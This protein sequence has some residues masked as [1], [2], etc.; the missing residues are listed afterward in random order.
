MDYSQYP[1]SRKEAQQTKAKYYF[2]GIPCKHGHI[3]LRKTKGSCVECNKR[4]WQNPTQKRI[5]YV[6]AYNKSE[7]GKAM[8]RRYY[9]ANKE[10]VIARAQSRPDEDKRRYKAKHK[11]NNPEYYC[12]LAGLRHRRSKNARPKWLTATQKMEIRLK[13]RLAVALTKATG[14]KYVVDHIVPLQGKTV[15]GLHVSWNLQVITQA[16]NCRKSNKL[17]D[18]LL[19]T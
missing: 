1:T 7:V 17:L 12:E 6:K 3:A 9:E 18:N 2:T 4:D 16:E 13:Y 11:K 8:K 14:I 15:C 10:D 19:K 5:E